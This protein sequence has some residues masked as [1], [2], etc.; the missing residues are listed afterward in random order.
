MKKV[1]IILFLFVFTSSLYSQTIEQVKDLMESKK[2]EV[3][4][5]FGYKQITTN[6]YSLGETNFI[7]KIDRGLIY[8]TTCKNK[9]LRFET[10]I[11]SYNGYSMNMDKGKQV[12]YN[13]YLFIYFV[14]T[15]NEI[16]YYN[17]SFI[18]KH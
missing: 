2:Y 5:Q 13:N 4:N 1:S 15:S 18:K 9:Y 17:L 10:T 14:S 12:Y 16:T 6:T 3:L 7:T 11:D 8:I